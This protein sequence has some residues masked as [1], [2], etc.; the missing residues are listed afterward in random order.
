MADKLVC[1]VE[2]GLIKFRSLYNLSR[3]ID[4]STI[5]R[6][7]TD[8]D[9]KSFVSQYSH[10]FEIID[11]NGFLCSTNRNARKYIMSLITS[12]VLQDRTVESLQAV[13]AQTQLNLEVQNGKIVMPS[14]SVDIT[15]L[16]RF[17]NDSR[18]AGPISGETIH[19]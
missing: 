17:L 6:M 18:Y 10:L 14:K 3:V 9:V 7:A 19:H 8:Q 12:E 5:F 16:M 1:I 11:I 4:T 15:E 13:A 2:N